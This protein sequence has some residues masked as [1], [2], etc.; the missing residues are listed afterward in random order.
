ME[1]FG[2]FKEEVRARQ[3]EQT[4]TLALTA[5]QKYV[6]QELQMLIG[7]TRNIDIQGQISQMSDIFKQPLY[8][9]VRQELNALKNRQVKGLDLLAALGKIYQ[10]YGLRREEERQSDREENPLPVII[11]SEGL[12]N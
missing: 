3:A 4:H 8:Q 5:A 2:K 11:C 12:V 7:Q 10:R 1:L 6:L 9:A